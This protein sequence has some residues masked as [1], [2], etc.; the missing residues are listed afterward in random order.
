M[1]GHTGIMV[2]HMML[3]GC[4]GNTM[5]RLSSSVE[6]ILIGKY[7]I[8]WYNTDD[9]GRYVEVYRTQV[10]DST[11]NPCV[12]VYSIKTK[13]AIKP[14]VLLGILE[15]EREMCD[16]K[17]ACPDHEQSCDT[18]LLEP[19]CEQYTSLIRAVSSVINDINECSREA[20]R[21]VR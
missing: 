18:C 16:R 6:N 1:T 4:G 9:V 20:D 19:L 17:S 15:Y 7:G 11:R 12:D 2:R 14:V 10:S 3:R 8:G 21:Y 5:I 13:I